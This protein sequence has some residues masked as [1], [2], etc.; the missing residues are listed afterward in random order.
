MHIVLWGTYD[1]GKPRVRILTEGL[2][3]SGVTITEC[4]ASIW[5]DVEDKSQVNGIANKAILLIR[6]LLSYPALVYRYMRAPKHDAVMVSY[7]GHLD[8]L[9]LWP[10]AKLRGTPIIWDAFLS[11]YNTVVQDRH[12]L[13]RWNPGAQLLYAWEWLACRAADKIILDTQ[14]HADYFIHQYSLEKDKV[15]SVF[16]GAE[17]DHFYPVPS[18][19]PDKYKQDVS[20]LFYGQFIPL[21]GI[22]V[23]V[24]TAN[25]LREHNIRWQLIGQGQEADKISDMINQ[26]PALNLTWTPWVKYEEINSIINK[27]DVCLGIFG[28][29]EKAR[30]VIPNKVFQIVS[31]G[32]PLITMDS[33]AI[34]ELVNCD[35]NLITLVPENNPEA[36]AGAVLE[37]TSSQRGREHN[38]CC[39]EL[40]KRI[41][42]TFIGKQLMGIILD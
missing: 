23:I 18:N 17:P 6:W 42:P 9:I 16:V 5:Q 32:A 10:F 11:L 30:M 33:P 31:A 41:S 25:I 4:H 13:G 38:V 22:D 29:T 27:A 1:T 7:M 36:L 35:C 21:H 14:Q 20:V 24:N 40:M 3:S 19:R 34:R 15:Y 26:L 12:M 37:M 28:A 2:R 8:V 39:K